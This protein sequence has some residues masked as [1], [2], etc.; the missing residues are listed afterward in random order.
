MEGLN[1]LWA[2]LEKSH[3][4]Y[5]FA[6][7]DVIGS[8]MFLGRLNT[9]EFCI[10]EQLRIAKENSSAM[11]DKEKAQERLSKLSGGVAVFKVYSSGFEHPT[12]SFSYTLR[13]LV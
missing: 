10:F 3:W 9:D 12:F 7:L 8:P 6:W 1:S 2:Y 11:F 13:I 5:R 4:L